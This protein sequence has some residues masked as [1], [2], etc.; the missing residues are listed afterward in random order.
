MLGVD[1]EPLTYEQLPTSVEFVECSAASGDGID[2]LVDA[3]ALAATS[4]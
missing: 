2:A 3:I 4:R 1:G